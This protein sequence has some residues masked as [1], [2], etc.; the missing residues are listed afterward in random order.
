MTDMKELHILSID[1]L[2][3]EQKTVNG[4]IRLYKATLLE[5]NDESLNGYVVTF[6]GE[7]HT[8]EHG[9]NAHRKFERL[10]DKHIF[11]R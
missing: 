8:F 10:I 5:T 3:G 9:K 7:V 11:Y 6:M 2:V 4:D 1:E